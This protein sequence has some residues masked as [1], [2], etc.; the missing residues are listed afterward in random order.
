MLVNMTCQ[1][2]SNPEA[3]YRIGFQGSAIAKSTTSTYI[4]ASAVEKDDGLY[5]CIASNGIGR[6]ASVS[7]QLI[8]VG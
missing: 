1:S 8:V 7:I 3:N 5:E 4:I 6:P 2:R